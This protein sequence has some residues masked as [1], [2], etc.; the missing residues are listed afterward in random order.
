MLSRDISSTTEAGFAPWTRRARRDASRRRRFAEPYGREDASCVLERRRGRV[1][2]AGF[3]ALLFL[4]AI[5]PA[6]PC[7]APPGLS[8]GAAK[9]GAHAMPRERFFFLAIRPMS[10]RFSSLRTIVIFDESHA[11]RPPH[12]IAYAARAA[13]PPED[14]RRRSHACDARRPLPAA[15]AEPARAF[16]LLLAHQGRQCGRCF[17]PQAFR[18]DAAEA[19]ASRIAFSPIRGCSR[20]SLLARR[21]FSGRSPSFLADSRQLVTPAADIAARRRASQD[22]DTARAIDAGAPG[23]A[24]SL[25]HSVFSAAVIRRSR[26]VLD[27][28]ARRRARSACLM[29]HGSRRTL[30]SS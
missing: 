20:W 24:S 5:Y 6:R 3:L 27:A 14:Y 7:C 25:A 11:H 8:R 21:I 9:W 16:R 29:G 4:G 23:I 10:Q 1:D 22:T 13:R 2:A 28:G 26:R 15:P 18:H 17:S 12:D 30:R 19:Y